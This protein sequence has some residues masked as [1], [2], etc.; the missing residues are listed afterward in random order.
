M[1]KA[2][3]HFFST[4]RA[5]CL[6]GGAA[7]IIRCLFSPF[8]FYLCVSTKNAQIILVFFCGCFSSVS[9]ASSPYEDMGA[10]DSLYA[11]AK[12]AL[13]AGEPRTVR[14]IYFLPNDRPFQQAVVDSMNVTIRQIQTFLP[15]RWMR[16]DTEIRPF[17]LK[18]M[19][20][21]NR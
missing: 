5:V 12:Q 15:I 18:P 4:M 21:A 13:N 17:A 20:R 7:Q 8:A 3:L 11:A 2:V 19:H 14:M 6:R 9:Y 1:K 10:R 16:V